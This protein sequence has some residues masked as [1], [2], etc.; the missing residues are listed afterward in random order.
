MNLLSCHVLY[1]CFW[2][3]LLHR[4]DAV[5]ASFLCRVGFT[6]CYWLSVWGPQSESKLSR[7]VFK[8]FKM[9]VCH[10]HHEYWFRGMPT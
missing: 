6:R 3:V 5:H 2:S 4:L 7:G 9:R 1:F 8:D 10:F